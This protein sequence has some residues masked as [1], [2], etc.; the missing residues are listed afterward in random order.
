MRWSSLT[1]I[2]QII[3]FF[4]DFILMIQ[5]GIF[6]FILVTFLTFVFLVRSNLTQNR[7][8]IT[9]VCNRFFYRGCP[10]TADRLWGQELID[11][12]RDGRRRYFSP[13]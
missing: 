6:C 2:T 7:I 8:T 4:S 12:I 3:G 10:G 9:S 1:A 11:P 5:Y 13:P